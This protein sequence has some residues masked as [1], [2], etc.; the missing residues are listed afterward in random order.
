MNV[1]CLP[2][3]FYV[4]SHVRGNVDI[5]NNSVVFSVTS[6]GRLPSEPLLVTIQD[7]I[8]GCLHTCT[9][10]LKCLS[11]NYQRISRKCELLADILLKVDV[12]DDDGWESYGHFTVTL[13]R[14]YL[15]CAFSDATLS[16][17]LR[18][19]WLPL[20]LLSF[21]TTPLNS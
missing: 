11:I 19:D 21:N 2:I 20:V 16:L 12:I 18:R 8:G 4:G 1:L 9:Q 5:T 17:H 15:Y 14:N 13:V 3:F 6:F 7:N 10:H